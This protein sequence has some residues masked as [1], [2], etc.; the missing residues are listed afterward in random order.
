MSYGLNRAQQPKPV[1]GYWWEKLDQAAPLT[2][3][4]EFLMI[5]DPP[6]VEEILPLAVWGERVVGLVSQGCAV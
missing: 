4:F 6:W 3:L 5:F 1:Q 2:W